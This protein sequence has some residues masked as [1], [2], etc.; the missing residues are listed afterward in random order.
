MSDHGFKI[1][2]MCKESGTALDES[3]VQ[4]LFYQV[5]KVCFSSHFFDDDDD[6]DFI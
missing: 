2:V 6:D 5:L 4:Q 3:V 1:L